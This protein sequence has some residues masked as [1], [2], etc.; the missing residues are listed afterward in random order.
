MAR[1]YGEVGYATTEEQPP[2]SGVHVNVITERDY[3]GDV[4]RDSRRWETGEKINGDISLGNSVS[5]VADEHALQ[6]Y[7]DI[8]YIRMDGVCWEVT[9]VEVKHPRLLLTFGGVY[10]GPTG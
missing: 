4:I 3:F 10:N 2:G 8:R 9:T 7:S 1:F 5:V 6:H